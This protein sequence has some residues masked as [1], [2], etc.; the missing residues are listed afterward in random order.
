[1]IGSRPVKGVYA[2]SRDL[3]RL[4]LP[5]LEN[6]PVTET[7]APDDWQDDGTVGIRGWY[8]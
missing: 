5:S 8:Y 3:L 6:P 7:E 1:M 4:M 2:L